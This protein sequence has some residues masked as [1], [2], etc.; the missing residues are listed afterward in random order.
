[1]QGRTSLLL[2]VVPLALAGV[3]H[4][5]PIPATL[6]VS[7]GINPRAAGLE[8]AVT[9]FGDYTHSGEVDSPTFHMT[10]TGSTFDQSNPFRYIGAGFSLE[11][12]TAETQDYVVDVRLAI[13]G[14]TN[15][16]FVSSGA[17]VPYLLAFNDP[18]MIAAGH[19]EGIPFLSLMVNGLAVLSTPP[20]DRPITELFAYEP[21]L[22]PGSPEQVPLPTFDYGSEIHSLGFRLAFSLSAGGTM[23]VRAGSSAAPIPEP[24][25]LALV[26]IAGVAIRIGQLVKRP[27]W[28]RGSPGGVVLHCPRLA[29]RIDRQVRCSVFS[30]PESIPK[31]TTRRPCRAKSI[32]SPRQFA[33]RQATNAR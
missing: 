24:S 23:D 5:T 18:N 12:R 4:G 28:R 17:A 7:D 1:M 29:F 3:A 2:L 9:E 31:R 10:W 30:A 6:T 27:A 26:L 19:R 14:M 20:L 13:D 11:N 15:G 25:S 8:G 22:P 32:R 21:L 33:S 16:A